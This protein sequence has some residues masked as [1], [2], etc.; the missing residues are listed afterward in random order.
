[1]P[2]RPR[3]ARQRLG[4][5]A[6]CF[7]HLFSRPR[8]FVRGNPKLPECI[9]N[10]QE[11][12]QPT[13]AKELRSFLCMLNVYRRF[14][15]QAADYQAPLHDALAGVRGNQPVTWT[16]TLVQ[17][18]EECKA[19]LCTAMLLT[20]PVPDT[21]LGLFTDASSLAIGAAFVQRVDNTWH[22]FSFFSK[23]LNSKNDAFSRQFH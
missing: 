2:R 23:K 14:L 13:P 21:P 3:P 6:R 15:L 12:P 8:N 18:F 19:A 20:H 10:L 9:S 7:H 17:I 4:E 5:H 22:P 16:P 1:M 11:Y